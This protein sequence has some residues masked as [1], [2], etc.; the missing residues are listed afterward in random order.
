[1][2]SLPHIIFGALLLFISTFTPWNSTQPPFNEIIFQIRNA[3]WR[4]VIITDQE[5]S[6]CCV[7]TAELDHLV[8]L[9]SSVALTHS[10]QQF[11]NNDNDNNDYKNMQKYSVKYRSLLFLYFF[12]I[13][14]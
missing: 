3:A 1:M 9:S 13:W 11:D 14:Y 2:G 10:Q 8:L 12:Q 6:H 7:Y 5:R 4:P